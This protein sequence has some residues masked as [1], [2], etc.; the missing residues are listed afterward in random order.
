V[1]GT[2]AQYVNVGYEELEKRGMAPEIIDMVKWTNQYGYFYPKTENFISATRQQFPRLK[3]FKEW[4]LRS[5]W[6]V[7][8]NTHA[9]SHVGSSTQSSTVRDVL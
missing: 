3:S 2:P 7:G 4:L 9:N 5:D 6:T 1:T 8:S